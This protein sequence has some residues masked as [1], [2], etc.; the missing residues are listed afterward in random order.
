[1]K[2]HVKNANLELLIDG[3]RNVRRAAANVIT[4]VILD[5]FGYLFYLTAKKLMGG[6][7]RQNLLE[8]KSRK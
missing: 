8:C 3:E 5:C 7:C 1:M 4:F 2:N 6:N